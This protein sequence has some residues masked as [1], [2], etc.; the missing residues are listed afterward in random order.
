MGF[1]DAMRRS[2]VHDA[3]LKAIGGY[4]TDEQETDSTCCSPR[5]RHLTPTVSTRGGESCEAYCPL[6]S[7]PSVRLR[8][9][10]FQ[11][12]KMIFDVP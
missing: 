6:I 4:Q 9:L 5:T 2:G 10:D 7:T 12:R 3:V 11:Y 1:I 8:S